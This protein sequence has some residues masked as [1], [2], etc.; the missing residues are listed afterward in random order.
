MSPR[1]TRLFCQGFYWALGRLS[2]TIIVA[3]LLVV[4]PLGVND[5]IRGESLQELSLTLLR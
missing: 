3:A 5:A 2:I 4:E 1:R